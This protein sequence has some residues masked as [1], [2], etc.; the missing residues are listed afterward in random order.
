MISPPQVVIDNIITELSVE[1]NVEG[2]ILQEIIAK[3]KPPLKKS[4]NQFEIKGRVL[5]KNGDPITRAT[6]KALLIEFPPPPPPLPE[7]GGGDP[8]QYTDFENTYFELGAAISLPPAE[9]N[10]NG[11]FIQNRINKK[12]DLDNIVEF[13]ESEY[14]SD[15]ENIKDKNADTNISVS[16]IVNFLNINFI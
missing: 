15:N 2:L 5:N 14:D 16:E 10:D 4:T 13:R 7:A 12:L 8:Q 6:V 1:L 11:E 3:L 9:V